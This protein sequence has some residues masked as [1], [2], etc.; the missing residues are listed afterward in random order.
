MP[1]GMNGN[2]TSNLRFTIGN[3]PPVR[4]EAPQL[5]MINVAGKVKSTKSPSGWLEVR[6]WVWTARAMR[7]KPDDMTNLLPGEEMGL[8]WYGEWV[9]EGE[10]TNEGRQMLLD[11]LN[12]GVVPGGPREWELVRDR[13]GGGRIW[14]R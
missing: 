12:H 13:S 3:F 4:D 14:L 11:I 8:G 1:I 7:Y 6:K 9:F 10:G 5:A 2:N